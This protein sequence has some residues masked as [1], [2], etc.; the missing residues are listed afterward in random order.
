MQSFRRAFPLF[1]VFLLSAT[2]CW[3]PRLDRATTYPVSGRLFIR[4]VPAVNAR[5][6]LRAVD[7]K[8]LDLL[9]PH[10]IAQADGLFRLTTF[11]TDDGA[12][13]GRYALTVTWPAP[14]KKR[15]DPEGPDRLKGR[16]ADPRRPMSTVLITP[17]DNELG[18]LDIQ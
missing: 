7:D 2:G 17:G 6:E 10:A 11:A 18:R 1:A 12:P 5:I 4:G 14:P 15:F 3:L 8:E 13:P 16:F 9:R